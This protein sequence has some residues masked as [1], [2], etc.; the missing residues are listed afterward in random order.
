MLLCPQQSKN[1]LTDSLI[2]LCEHFYCNT[3]ILI[4][5]IYLDQRY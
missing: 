3:F 2:V 1:Q 4:K 5:A